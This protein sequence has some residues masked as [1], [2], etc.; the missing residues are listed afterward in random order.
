MC[1]VNF[2][3]NNIIVQDKLASKPDAGLNTRVID[4][5]WQGGFIIGVTGLY[6]FFFFG[7][8][9]GGGGVAIASSKPSF[10]LSFHYYHSHISL[11]RIDIY[12]RRTLVAGMQDEPRQAKGIAFFFHRP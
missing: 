1:F 9:G 8:G 12:A 5:K 2:I 10:F 7:G 11:L 6:R 3:Y 4:I